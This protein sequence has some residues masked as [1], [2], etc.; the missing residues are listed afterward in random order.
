M[1]TVLRRFSILMTMILEFYILGTRPKRLIV[2]AVFVM[3]FGAI[4]AAA[5]DLGNPVKDLFVLNNSP[6]YFE[7]YLSGNKLT[8]EQLIVLFWQTISLLRRTVSTQSHI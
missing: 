3:I 2:L 6:I 4:V 8:M 1:F 5:N 7:L